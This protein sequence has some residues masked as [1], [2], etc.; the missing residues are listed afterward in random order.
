MPAQ[1]R[2]APAKK[3]ARAAVAARREVRGEKKPPAT[4]AIAFRGEKFDVP[5]D[6]LG[7]AFMQGQYMAEFGVSGERISKMLFRLLGPQD[8]ARFVDS[9][10]PGDN[11]VVVADEFLQAL[12]KAGNVPNS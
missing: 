5:V 2:N 8:S 6:R 10:G 7:A 4:L 12:N 3:T 1:P 9:I 11:I